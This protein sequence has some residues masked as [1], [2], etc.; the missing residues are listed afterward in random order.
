[1]NLL[2]LVEGRRAEPRIY[3]AW[4][5][6]EYPDLTFVTRPEEITENCCRIVPG[7]G[8]PNLFSA[9]KIDGTPSK[10]EACLRDIHQYNN[11]DHFFICVDAD[12][13]TYLD[14]QQAVQAKLQASPSYTQIPVKTQVHIIVQVCCLETWLLGNTA[15]LRSVTTL[16]P[17]PMLQ[18]FI[19]Y[20]DVRSEDPE[21]M[22]KGPESQGFITKAQFHK[23]YLKEYIRQVGKS[24]SEKQCK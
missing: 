10:L 19:Q 17:T 1:M 24:Y 11:I 21:K 8:Y 4:L 16:P 13:D 23:R 3:K 22:D 5:Q 15:I 20:Y 18:E 2:F 6:A 9:S 12:E 14:R 7:N